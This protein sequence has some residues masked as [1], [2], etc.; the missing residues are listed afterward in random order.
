MVDARLL[1]EIVRRNPYRLVLVGDEAQLPPVGSGQP[2]HDLVRLMPSCVSTLAHC[3]RNSEAIYCVSQSVRNGIVPEK[4]VVSDNE[5]CRLH[6]TRGAESA[7]RRIVGMVEDGG[8]D[9]ARDIVVCAVNGETD[10]STPCSVESLNKDIKAIVNPGD[11]TR[12]FD[13]GDRVICTVNTPGIDCWN[14]TTGTVDCFDHAGDMFV[15][16]DG[17]DGRNVRV[18]RVSVKDWKLAYALTVHKSQGSQYRKVVFAA[19]LRDARVLLDR[20]MVYTAVTRARKECH[21]VG[22][23]DALRAAISSVPQKRTV[24]QELFAEKAK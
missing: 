2:F 19:T 5:L 8:I 20:S 9:F 24:L 6:S 21:I 1:A 4:D 18:P 22:D 12:R 16:L 7:H 11:G 14:G 17:E 10:G 3:Y 13:D 15:W 23:A